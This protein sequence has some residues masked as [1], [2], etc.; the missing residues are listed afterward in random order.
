MQRTVGLVIIILL[1]T[2]NV[3]IFGVTAVQS[4]SKP[5]IPE[6]TLKFVDYSYDIPIEYGI[7][8]YTGQTV[9]TKS[10][11]HIDNRTIEITIKNQPFNNYTDPLSG[12]EINLFYNI[13]YKGMFTENWT[14]M[15]GG[16]GKMI[17]YSMDSAIAQNGYPTQAYGSQYTKILFPLSDNIPN[18]VEMQFQVEAL[19]GYTNKHVQ[20]ARII[21]SIIDYTFA[22][23]KS[24][25]SNTQT[26]KIGEFSSSTSNPTPPIE[27]QPTSTPNQIAPT[28]STPNWP[29][30]PTP[31]SANENQLLPLDSIPLT[32]FLLVVTGLIAVILVLSIFAFR[33]HQNL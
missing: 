10:G 21:F 6:F 4:I 2:T 25:W 8:Q 9:V 26:I 22:G 16:T 29:Y 5:S 3:T 18:N 27:P 33:K 31:L 20:D 14:E 17:T 7:D 32:T 11:Q 28:N 15:Y 13:R 24:G 30:N 23:Q 1:A 12:K 19:E